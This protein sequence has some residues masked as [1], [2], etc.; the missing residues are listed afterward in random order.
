MSLNEP[1]NP[2]G[3]NYSDWKFVDK[4]SEGWYCIYCRRFTKEPQMVFESKPIVIYRKD[5][6]ER[7]LI[8]DHYDGCRGWE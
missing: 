6:K 4:T 3:S 8:Y 2:L 1:K 7:W 5:L